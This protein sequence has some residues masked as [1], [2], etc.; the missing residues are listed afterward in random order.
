VQYDAKE[1]AMTRQSAVAAVTH[2]ESDLNFADAER[3]I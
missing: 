2:F 3:K 1:S